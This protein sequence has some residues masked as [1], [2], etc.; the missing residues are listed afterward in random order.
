MSLIK[1]QNIENIIKKYHNYIE[2]QK[3]LITSFPFFFIVHQLNH[4]HLHAVKTDMSVFAYE[5]LKYY[6]N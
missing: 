1:Y 5:L 2:R 4:I 3:K 6:F